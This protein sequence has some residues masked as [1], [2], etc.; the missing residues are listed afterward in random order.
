MRYKY[1]IHYLLRQL[2]LSDYQITWIFF[3]EALN[4]AKWTWKSWI[5]IKKDDKREIPQDS[6]LK[7]ATFF[8]CS[9]DELMN[10]KANRNLKEEFENLIHRL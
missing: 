3:P 1:R 8:E 6:L 5:Y 7:I 2:S 10:V 9:I 4:I